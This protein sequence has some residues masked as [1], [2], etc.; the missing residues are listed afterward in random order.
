MNQS[1]KRNRLQLALLSVVALSLHAEHLALHTREYFYVGGKYV[2]QT[3]SQ[4]RSGQM[5]VEAL[6]PQRV[7]RKYPLV[8]IHGL[9]QTATNWL[10][11]P[12][13]RP[14][15]ADYFL[16]QGYVVYLVDQPARGRSTWQPTQNGP[17]QTMSASEVSRRFTAPEVGGNWQQGKKHTQWPGDGA[18]KGQMGDPV[19]DAFYATQVESLSN[20]VETETLIQAAGSALLDKIGPAIILTHSQSGAFG[21]LIADSRPKDVKA[22]VAV[23]PAGPPFQNEVVNQDKNREWGLTDIALTY[24][25]PAKSAAELASARDAKADGPDL[26]VCW[27]QADPPRRLPNLAGIPVMIVT[28][29]ASYHAVYDQCTSRYLTQAG[30]PNTFVRLEDIGIHGNGHMMMLEKNNIEIAAALEKWIAA[31]VK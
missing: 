26:A 6:R 16:N 23:E 9:G 14:G 27:K 22:I 2:G 24:D 3:G 4:V 7:T 5:Y 28:A 25:P 12:D 11:T 21:W 8:F 19:F 1:A 10:A 15:W 31:H 17:V 30:V 29:E 18:Q 13:G 20:A